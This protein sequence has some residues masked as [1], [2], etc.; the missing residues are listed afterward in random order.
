M[1][2]FKCSKK[3]PQSKYIYDWDFTKSLYDKVQ[4]EPTTLYGDDSKIYQS[5]NGLEIVSNGGY[6]KV[7]SINILEEGYTYEIDFGDM[8][9]SFTT[10]TACVWSRTNATAYGLRFNSSRGWYIYE[11]SSYDTQGTP[12]YDVEVF[13]NKRLKAICTNNK[14]YIYCVDEINQT[15]LNIFEGHRFFSGNKQSCFIGSKGYTYRN[16]IVKAFRMYRNIDE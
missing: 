5:A 10:G 15:E 14:L 11:G 8:T 16:M 6:A 1:A 7:G 3:I 9:P 2:Y 13:K 12:C 4:N